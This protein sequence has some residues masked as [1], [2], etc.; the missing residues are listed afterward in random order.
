LKF[1]GPDIKIRG[2]CVNVGESCA[3]INGMDEVRTIRLAIQMGSGIQCGRDY[4]QPVIRGQG[5]VAP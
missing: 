4:R 3:I 2:G 5:A 1:M